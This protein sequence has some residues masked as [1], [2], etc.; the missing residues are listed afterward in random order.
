MMP[1]TPRPFCTWRYV[2]STPVGTRVEAHDPTEV[3]VLLER[4]L[5]VLDGG[6]KLAHRVLALLD[7]ELREVVGQVHEVGRLG[8]EVGLGPQLHERGNLPVTGDRHRALAVLAVGALGRLAEAAARAATAPP[9]SASPSFSTSAFFA[10]I[11]PAPVSWRSAWTS[12][13]EMSAILC[14]LSVLTL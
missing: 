8:H 12:F 2:S 14:P 4:Q 9:P 11:I 6:G 3:D 5:E 7:D 10:S 1:M 13:A